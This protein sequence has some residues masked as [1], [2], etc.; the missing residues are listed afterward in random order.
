M[1]NISGFI[2]DFLRPHVMNHELVSAYK[3]M[4]EDEERE[5]EAL[6]W[7]EATCGDNIH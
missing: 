3:A 7:T 4:A 6:E 1:N 5:R 2:E